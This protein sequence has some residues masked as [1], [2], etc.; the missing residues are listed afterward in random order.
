VGFGFTH[1]RGVRLSYDNNIPRNIPLRSINADVSA[2]DCVRPSGTT[3]LVPPHS[4]ASPSASNL[5]S[6]KNS[7][8]K[9]GGVSSLQSYTRWYSGIGALAKSIAMHG[10]LSEDIVVENITST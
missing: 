2:R 7:K 1:N 5:Y 3:S 10:R 9:Q 8:A 6:F 4:Y